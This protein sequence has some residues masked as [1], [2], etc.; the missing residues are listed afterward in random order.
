MKNKKTKKRSDSKTPQ[1]SIAAKRR[2]LLE[3]LMERP[4]CLKEDLIEASADILD[5]EVCDKTLKRWIEGV[6][7]DFNVDIIKEKDPV[8]GMKYS[9]SED[10]KER[11]PVGLY[12]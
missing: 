11:L 5:T 6:E 12:G 4:Y 2:W 10:S 9:L 1:I 3:R 8:K 7:A